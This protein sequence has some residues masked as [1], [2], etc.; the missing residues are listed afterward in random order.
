MATFGQKIPDDLIRYPALGFFNFHH[1]ADFWPSYPGPDPI[2]TMVRDGRKH[3]VLTMHRV[4]SVIDGGE[5]I[6]RS[7]P[8]AIPGG[9]TAMDMHR[10][11][12]PQMGPFIR[13][14]VESLLNASPMQAQDDLPMLLQEAPLEYRTQGYWEH[15]ERIAA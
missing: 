4:T 12:W 10:I 6:A 8:I 1:S 11:T 2:G 5:F 13:G 7:N 14:A 3:L 15:W 9:V